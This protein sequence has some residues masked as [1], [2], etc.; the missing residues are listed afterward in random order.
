M[1]QYLDP[2][3]GSVIFAVIVLLLLSGLIVALVWL[4]RRGAKRK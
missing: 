4:R 1:P 2:G 3:V